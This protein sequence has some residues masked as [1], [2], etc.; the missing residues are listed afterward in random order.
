MYSVTYRIKEVQQPRGGFLPISQFECINLDDEESYILHDECYNPSLLGTVVDYLTRFM[1]TKDAFMSF[2][3]SVIAAE[4]VKGK[5]F[6]QQLCSSITGLG[7]DSILSACELASYDVFYRNPIN[8]L[9]YSYSAPDE[10]TISHIRRMVERSVK[11]IMEDHPLQMIGITFE[12]GY[13]EIV[14]SGDA[15]YLTENTLWDMKVSK[16]QQP[17]AEE[18]LQL[19]MYYIMGCHSIHSEQFK[20]LSYIAIFN[21]RY[22]SIFRCSIQNI[23]AEL[24]QYIEDNVICYG[25][26]PEE[27]YV[28]K[29]EKMYKSL[30]SQE[31]VTTKEAA[32]LLGQPV[33]LIRWMVRRKYISVQKK[34]RGYLLNSKELLSWCDENKPCITFK[35]WHKLGNELYGAD[36]NIWK[37][38]CPNCGRVFKVSEYP[39]Y[40]ESLP[41]VICATHKCITWYDF[42]TDFENVT[43]GYKYIINEGNNTELALGGVVII[44]SDGNKHH[45]FMFADECNYYEIDT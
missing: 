39:K 21:P 29:H 17:T 40:K 22:N 1:L 16:R 15:D 7:K 34:G 41:N 6:V 12:E 38:V 31:W 43:C 24:I 36:Q 35:Q 20:K 28:K 3:F 27:A 30:D 19:L 23:S 10:Y 2:H 42:L 9:T 37:F 14:S 8:A 45:A 25:Q 5:G 26:T 32:E 11:A 4:S 13:S 18:T 33:E 44:D